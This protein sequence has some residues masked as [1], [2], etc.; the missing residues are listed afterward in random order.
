MD[1]GFH[2]PTVYFPLIVPEAMMIEPTET[3][4]RETLD[5]FVTAMNAI[6]NEEPELVK[7][8]PHTMPVRRVDEVE[9]AKRLDIAWTA[10]S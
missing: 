6:A 4:S 3:E 8:A 1:Y 10:P 5:D 9:A 7:T 2:P